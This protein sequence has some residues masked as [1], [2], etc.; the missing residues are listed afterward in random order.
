MIVTV[1]IS[2]YPLSDEFEP[3]VIEFIHRLR[4]YPDI[5]VITN[6]MSTQLRGE[7]DAVANAL[8]E[9]QREQM[10]SGGKMVFVVRWL[11]SDLDIGRLP[12]IG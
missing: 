10:E 9:C 2:L 3:R 12:D 4:E 1:D 5:E 7:Y 11:N 6:Q 8:T